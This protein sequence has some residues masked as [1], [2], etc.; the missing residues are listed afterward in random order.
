MM[1]R[2]IKDIKVMALGLLISGAMLSSCNNYL[3]IVPDDGIATVDMS[4]NMRST[5]IKWLYSCYSYMRYEDTG[6]LNSDPS[7]MGGDELWSE[8]WRDETIVWDPPMLYISRGLQSAAHT[9]ANDMA[10]LYQA[11]RYCNTLIE[12]I[13]EVPDIPLWE[14]EQWTAETK[15]LKAYYHFLI[16]RKWGPMPIVRENLPVSASVEEVRVFRENIDD[17]FDYALSLIDEA[18]PYLPERPR[19]REEWGRIDQSAAAAI[20]ARI[21]VF[22]AS[23]LFNNNKDQATLISNNERLF[24]EKTEAQEKARWEYAVEACKKA[25]EI[26][27]DSSKELY[28][29]QGSLHVN[30]TLKRELDLREVICEEFNDEALW[31]NTQSYGYFNQ[32]YVCINLAPEQYTDIVIRGNFVA[33]PLKIANQFYTDHGVPVEHDLER[34]SV[35]PEAIRDIDKNYRWYMKEG[36]STAEFNFDRE[37]RF[38]ADL[39]FDGSLWASPNKN[40][41]TSGEIAWAS[42]GRNLSSPTGYHVKKLASHEAKMISQ[43]SWTTHTYQWNVMR[44]ADLYLLYAEA[45]NE[46]E[47]P[48]GP[49]SAEMFKYIDLVRERA[50]IPGV[51]EAWDNYSDSPGYYSTQYGMRQIIHRERLIELAFEGQRF[52]DLRRWKEAPAQWDENV[53]GWNVNKQSV[54]EQYYTSRELFK[55]PSF[56]IKDYFWPIAN[57]DIE[58]NPNLVQNIGW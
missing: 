14:K 16:F 22:A 19:S 25:I 35:N 44:L 36:Y 52:W 5:A 50:G 47:G 51:K 6:D 1:S 4:F 20:K 56:T 37:P 9:Y 49:S 48:D 12:R 38:Y 18:L 11:L 26:C 27:H 13:N 7:L 29:Y 30:D 24:P 54:K 2:L 55:M 28:T 39:G 41:P 53:C 58:Q 57:S 31:V 10:A 23:P 15:V 32:D 45:I 17:C 46:L 34:S 33:V 21:A 3:D 40:N 8:K 42:R 43:N